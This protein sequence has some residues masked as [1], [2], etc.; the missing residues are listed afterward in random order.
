MRAALKEALLPAAAIAAA[1]LIFGIVVSFAGVSPVQVW[2]LLF[3]GAFGDWYSWQNTLQR[4]APLMLTALCVA[5]PARAGLVII[6][7]EGALVLGGLACAAL[8]QGLPLPQNMAGTVMVCV[9]GAI[10]GGLWIALAGWLRQFRGINETISSL[11]LAYVAI[12]LFKHLVEG[13]LRDPGSLNKPSSFALGEGLR[14][15]GVA[16]S[17]VHWGLILGVIACAL[18]A[19]WLRWTPSGFSVRVVG[20]NLRT[21][22]L[23]GLPAS[24]LVLLACAL[25][26][27]CAGLA[28]AV[29]VAAVHTS[30]NAA[31]IAG[32]GYT[33][34]LVSFIARHHPLAVIPV[35]V[36]F[37]GFGAAGSLLQ[38]RLGLPDA[39]VL[40]LQ[41]IAFVL[42]L[43]SEALRDVDW[44]RVWG[45]VIAGSTRNPGAAVQRLDPGS[46]PG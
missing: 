34:I 32:Y 25:G 31:L 8:A 44:K 2:L 15:A 26:G 18:S 23:M 12:G 21:A 37:G 24:R 42:I 43:A 5:I 33:G 46:S 1:L 6:G 11:L 22:Q 38:R 20:G 35:A 17:D 45:R 40:L 9:A 10:A 7:G 16:G 19:L 36:L 39:S 41:G 29:E 27:G 3:K 14:I 30:A 4:A 13:P 28:G